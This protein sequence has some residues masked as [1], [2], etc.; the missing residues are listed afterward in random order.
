VA[1]VLV[2]TEHQQE[3]QVLTVQQNQLFLLPLEQPLL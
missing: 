3:H 2:V 1:V